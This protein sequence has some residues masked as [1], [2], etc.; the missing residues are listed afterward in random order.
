M[1]PIPNGHTA[2]LADLGAFRRR[3]C[4]FPT[5]AL[6]PTAQLARELAAGADR[7]HT[8]ALADLWASRTNSE[9][10][11]RAAVERRARRA[12]MRSEWVAGQ[13]AREQRRRRS[14]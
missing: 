6:V 13:V 10:A 4:H 3:V 9:A 14:E 8:A 5:S 2:T 1:E 12:A 7:V 11:R